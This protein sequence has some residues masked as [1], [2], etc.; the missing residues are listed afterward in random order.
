MSDRPNAGER[1]ERSVLAGA[2]FLIV[3]LVM[4]VP[5]GLCTGVFGG[6]ALLDMIAHPQNASDAVSILGTA[7][8]IGG[9]FVIAG[10]VLVRIGI[11]RLR[12]G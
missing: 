9:P 12:G 8:L 3:G 1:Q 4:L 6:G 2:A 7:L 10:I 11:S 5:S